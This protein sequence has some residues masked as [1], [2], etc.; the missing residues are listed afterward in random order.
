MISAW[1]LLHDGC[2]LLWSSGGVQVC[3]KGFT[4]EIDC[5]LSHDRP[6]SVVYT[7]SVKMWRYLPVSKYLVIGILLLLGNT[8]RQKQGKFC[9][10]G[11]LAVHGCKMIGRVKTDLGKCNLKVTR[12][13][14]KCFEILV[15]N[16]V[17]SKSGLLVGLESR[18]HQSFRIGLPDLLWRTNLG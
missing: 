16:P 7:G 3:F 10:S 18:A 13:D 1:W 15:S 2:T 4:E 11:K 12:P 8:K 14:G 6:P 9:Q 17:H 5:S